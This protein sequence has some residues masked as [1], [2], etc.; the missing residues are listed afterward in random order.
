MWDA[1]CGGPRTKYQ[2]QQELT[3][4]GED[5]SQYSANSALLDVHY[6]VTFLQPVS[7]VSAEILAKL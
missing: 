4:N 6:A 3:T 5:Q 1:C 2:E 7:Y